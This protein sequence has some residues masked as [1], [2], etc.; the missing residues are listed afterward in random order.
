MRRLLLC[1]L[2]ATLI[3]SS[4]STSLQAP[5]FRINA[6]SPAPG[7]SLASAP[8]EILVTLSDTI[9]AGSLGSA[10]VQLVRDGADNAFDTPDDVTVAP[11]SLTVVGG[12]QIR[13]DLTGVPLAN[14]T[15]RLRLLGNI[16]ISAGR[17]GWWRLDESIGNAVADSSGMGNHGTIGGNPTWLP[18]GGRIGGAL[19]FDGNGDFVIVP[20]AGSLQ[21]SGSMSVTLWAQITSVTSGFADLVRKA[22]ANQGG[23][24]IRWHHFTDHLWWRVDRYSNPQIFVQ[25]TQ[26]TTPYLNAWHHIAGT[27]DAATGTSSLYVDG[28]LKNSITGFTGPLEHTD[29][30][31]LMFTN[32]PGQVAVPGLLDDVRVYSRALSLAEVQSLAAA[33]SDE[34]VTDLSGNPIDG[35]FAGSFPSGNASPGGHFVS[36]F[37]LDTNLPVAPSLLIATPT[38]TGP[39]NLSWTDNS[40]NELGFRV[41]RGSDGVN[42]VEIASVGAGVAAY[43]DAWPPGTSFYRVRAFNAAGNGG[44]SNTASATPAGSASS[45][46]II[47]K[48]CGSAG[49]EVLIPLALAALLRRRRKA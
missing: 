13:L 28:V 26:V 10:T 6:V 39:I 2:F 5:T 20:Q 4:G 16:P 25:D 35:E 17:V 33:V 44:Y 11:A 36:T 38:G 15:Y 14:D 24:L 27:Y 12:N 32:H 48:G 8:A 46:L 31:Y 34:A 21:P 43:P 45:S 22:D 18:A 40:S 30:L 23:Y 37:V 1:G 9:Q 7:S 47:V 42:F 3:P 49:L 41:E 19:N 29:E